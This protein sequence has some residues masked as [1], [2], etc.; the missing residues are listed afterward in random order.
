MFESRYIVGL[1]WL[2]VVV[3]EGDE[4][5]WNDF[6]EEFLELGLVVDNRHVQVFESKAKIQ[7]HR[8]SDIK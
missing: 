8:Y 2:F 3:V 5:N 4:P 1:D 7:A 6:V